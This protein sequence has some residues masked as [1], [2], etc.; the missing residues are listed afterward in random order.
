MPPIHKNQLLVWALLRMSVRDAPPTESVVST[1][2]SHVS[3]ALV[4]S[5]LSP[6]AH[7]TPSLFLPFSS[8]PFSFVRFTCRDA[9]SSIE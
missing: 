7:A 9:A 6:S 3:A 1:L 5:R 4:L 2:P 8:D